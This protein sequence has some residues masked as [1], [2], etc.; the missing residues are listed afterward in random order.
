MLCAIGMKDAL[1][2]FSEP[3]TDSGWRVVTVIKN[4]AVLLTASVGPVSWMNGITVSLKK[5]PTSAT[6]KVVR[7]GEHEGKSTQFAEA[8]P[9]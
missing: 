9:I 3:L 4:T 8:T 1:R 5:G 6:C 7:L 2:Q